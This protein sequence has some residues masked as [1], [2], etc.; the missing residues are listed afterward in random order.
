MW[1]IQKL[2]DPSVNPDAK[3]FQS[4]HRQLVSDFAA[5]GGW[6]EPVKAEKDATAKADAVLQWVCHQRNHGVIAQKGEI[7][8]L[9]TS[10]IDPQP[11]IVRGPSGETRHYSSITAEREFNRRGAQT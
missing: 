9:Y 7:T 5:R 3:Y 11:Y 2:L 8:L 10:A 6:V 4:H 1:T